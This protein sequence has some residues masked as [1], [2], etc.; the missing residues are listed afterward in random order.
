MHD[1]RE[2]RR[3]WSDYEFSAIAAPFPADL[4]PPPS[5]YPSPVYLHIP[6]R[7]TALVSDGIDRVLARQDLTA[8]MDEEPYRLPKSLKTS[9][10]YVLPVANHGRLVFNGKIIGMRGDPLPPGPAPAPPIMLH[11]ARFFDGQCSNE[12]CT[13]RITHRETGEAFD[14][15]L[16]LLTTA[17]GQ[18]RTLAESTLADAIGISTIARTTDGSI[19]TVLQTSRNIASARLLAPSGSGSL[20]P[21]DI[22]HS[23]AELILQDVVRHG[24][25]RELREETGILPGEITGTQVIGFARWLERGAKPE[26]FGI[27]ELAITA[28]E[29]AERRHLASDER[30]YTDG[31]YPIRVDLAALGREL[32]DGTALLSAASLPTRVK[33]DGSLPLLLAIRAAALAERVP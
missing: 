6:G 30:L 14:P 23:N 29:L 19:V 3:R 24:M 15:R 27:T 2:L 9:A 10:R 8:R 20:D 31:T 26:F 32:A 18:L 25:E 1:V 7:G 5:A 21:R 22:E 12:M 4:I 11:V 17:T 33:E 28:E 13:L 16:N